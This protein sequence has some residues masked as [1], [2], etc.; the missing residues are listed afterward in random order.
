MTKHDKI[1]LELKELI[2]KSK[3]DEHSN[4]DFEKGYRY[5]IEQAIATFSKI[6]LININTD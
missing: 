6:D 3:K 2:K 5:G 1:K 4:T